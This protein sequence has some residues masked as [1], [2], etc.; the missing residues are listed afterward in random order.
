[1]EQPQIMLR[2]T[3]HSRHAD[4]RIHP[5]CAPPSER[6]KETVPVQNGGYRGLDRRTAVLPG[7]LSLGLIHLR[8]RPSACGQVR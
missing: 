3:V 1:M 8:P 4:G 6:V 2:R 5:F 7:S